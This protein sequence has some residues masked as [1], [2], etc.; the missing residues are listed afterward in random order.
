[1]NPFLPLVRIG[2][3]TLRSRFINSEFSV[4]IA[5]EDR[6]FGAR[7]RNLIVIAAMSALFITATSCKTSA[8]SKAHGGKPI[9]CATNLASTVPFTDKSLYQLEST[10][11]ND[12]G[13]AVKLA[14][15]HVRVQVVAMF[16]ASCT[17]AC[18]VIVQDLKRIEA[19]LPKDL[20][21]KV[22]F[23]LV[24]MDTERDTPSALHSYRAARKLPQDRWTL[25]RGTPDDTLEL[26][27][28]LGVKFRRESTGQFSHSNLITILNEQGEIIHQ[29]AGLNQDMDEALRP[30]KK[31]VADREPNPHHAEK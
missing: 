9:C 27:A 5:T 8:N 19:G 11:T 2:K 26:A 16:F 10:W 3:K 12:L 13:H 24:T 17:Y 4:W 14:E 1:M 22:G 20:R 31:A 28:L 29:I 30:I 15:L 6:R 21:A 23:T 7:M 18:P 25:L